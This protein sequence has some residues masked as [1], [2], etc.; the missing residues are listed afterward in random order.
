MNRVSQL[1]RGAA[2]AS[3]A[4][5]LAAFSHGIAGGEAPGAVGVGLAGMVAL[6]ASV[7]FVGR[8]VTPVRTA[9]AVVVSQGAFHLLFG[10]GA[11]SP[12]AVAVSGTGHHQ[13][14]TFLDGP[15]TAATHAWHSDVAML[16]G[17][18]VAAV[19]TIVY[20]LAIESAAWRAVGSAAR[21]F[22][23]RLTGAVPVVAV[24]GARPRPVT[25]ELPAV[26][27]LRLRYA[28]LRYRGPPVVLAS[29]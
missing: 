13:V 3:V 2:T 5:L 26:R 15:V 11:G 8:R 20:L 16:V 21:R 17:H 4:V 7:A 28:A 18:A 12:G 14:V 27:H 24:F 19:L 6:A 10:I 23:L 25:P 1:A 29:A 22:V 9:L